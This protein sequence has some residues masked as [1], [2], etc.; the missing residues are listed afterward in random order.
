MCLLL[1]EAPATA[2]SVGLALAPRLIRN[3]VKTFT[4]RRKRRPYHTPGDSSSGQGEA[5]FC[6]LAALRLGPDAA[7]MALNN[8]P[9]R[10]QPDARALEFMVAIERGC[11]PPVIGQ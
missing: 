10:G 11:F 8:P 5:E 4:A 6:A 7:A 2:A 3:W 9:R 1:T